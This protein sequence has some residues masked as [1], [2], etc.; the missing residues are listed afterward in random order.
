MTAIYLIQA[1]YV[2]TE[3]NYSQFTF[4]RFPYLVWNLQ[5]NWLAELQTEDAFGHNITFYSTLFL[6]ISEC[7]CEF[8]P[9]NTWLM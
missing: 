2:S 9:S 5:T 3:K 8:K 6:N 4:L 1:L 7:V